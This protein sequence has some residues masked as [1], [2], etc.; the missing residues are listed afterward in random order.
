MVNMGFTSVGGYDMNWHPGNNMLL[1]TGTL[2]SFAVV[3][4]SK[5]SWNSCPAIGVLCR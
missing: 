2:G 1:K 3:L 5:H 4:M